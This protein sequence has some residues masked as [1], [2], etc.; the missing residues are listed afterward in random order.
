ML[1]DG[2][3]NLNIG[4]LHYLIEALDLLVPH[5]CFFILLFHITGVYNLSYRPQNMSEE[6]QADIDQLASRIHQWLTWP[7]ASEEMD[8]M[9]TSGCRC[10][11]TDQDD[12]PH[13]VGQEIFSGTTLEDT[14]PSLD[15]IYR[16]IYF[17]LAFDISASVETSARFR[18][19][20]ITRRTRWPRR[21]QDVLPHGPEDTI[22]GCLSWLQSGHV[23]GPIAGSIVC[24]LNMT[25]HFTH[26]LTL[27]HM[28]RSRTLV[29]KAILDNITDACDR[30][31]GLDSGR[32]EEHVSYTLSTVH[33]VLQPVS[34]LM[35]AIVMLR[36]D[37]MQGRF[38]YGESA[39][40]LMAQYDRAWKSSGIQ[41]SQPDDYD[42]PHWH[43]GD[44]KSC[45]KRYAT[46][47][48]VLSNDYKE[49]GG[50]S[51]TDFNKYLH[52]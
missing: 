6:V 38:L 36:C 26:P 20:T 27:L 42:W 5:P 37:S 32:G 48:S 52:M 29:M 21:I 19:S 1:S 31:E 24:V 45:W 46:L 9:I 30:F 49:W 34:L 50:Y 2:T 18:I 47:G 25:L 22:R 44:R 23:Q 41:S 11:P 51:Q 39:L 13:R 12:R 4:C 3:E 7:R 8:T 15:F 35:A 16:S 40:E 33:S 28:L 43:V 10:S 14:P 17:V